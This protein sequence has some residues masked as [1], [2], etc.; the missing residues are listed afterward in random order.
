MFVYK[1]FIIYARDI[2]LLIDCT[3]ND[4]RDMLR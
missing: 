1:D 4:K 3:V 2:V